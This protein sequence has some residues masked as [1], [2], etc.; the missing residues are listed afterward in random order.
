MIGYAVIVTVIAVIM[1]IWIGKVTAK[2]EGKE[3][4]VKKDSEAA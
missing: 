3:D 4:K 2:A 1:T